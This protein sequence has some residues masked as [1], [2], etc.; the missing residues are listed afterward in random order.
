MGGKKSEIYF[1]YIFITHFGRKYIQIMLS[2]F[3]CICQETV[4]STS[5][6]PLQLSLK[7]TFEVS[8]NTTTLTY[9][10]TSE[11]ASIFTE[12]SVKQA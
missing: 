1:K 8:R 6:F 4:G 2:L 12:Y 9:L 5:N 7:A 10:S 11:Y 3:L